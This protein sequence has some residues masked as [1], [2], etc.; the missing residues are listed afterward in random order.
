MF[1]LQ[2]RLPPSVHPAFFSFTLQ[3]IKLKG[4]DMVWAS[5]KIICTWNWSVGLAAGWPDQMSPCTSL[6]IDI[7]DIVDRPFFALLKKL[8]TIILMDSKK[9][10]S[11]HQYMLLIDLVLR[12]AGG[13]ENLHFLCVPFKPQIFFRKWNYQLLGFLSFSA[14]IIFP[15][16]ANIKK[17]IM[18]R[19][20]LGWFW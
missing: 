18:N 17:R 8:D 19:F 1:Y 11:V 13:S 7:V 5:S 9:F 3:E 16:A 20:N 15:R 12:E 14:G 4:A 2:T 10:W 6:G